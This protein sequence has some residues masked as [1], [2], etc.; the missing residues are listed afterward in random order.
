MM[1][2]KLKMVAILFSAAL[3]IAFIT[4]YVY[5]QTYRGFFSRRADS[6]CLFEMLDLSQK[7]REKSQPLRDRFHAFLDRQGQKIKSRQ[8]ELIELLSYDHPNMDR[9]R[10]KQKEIQ[11]LQHQMQARVI[12]HLLEESA[13]YHSN[14]RKKFFSLIKNRMA[15]GYASRPRW[16][17][18]QRAKKRK[19]EKR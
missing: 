9:I 13:G 18:K 3:N 14:Q 10:V 11:S 5:H 19:Q 16:M 8:I 6:R 4:S 17:P 12:A 7:Q 15:K 2:N 1:K